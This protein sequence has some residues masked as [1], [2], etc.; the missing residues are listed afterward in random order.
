M[1]I[2]RQ[3]EAGDEFIELDR[4][5]PT[6]QLTQLKEDAKHG[7]DVV[8]S[9]FG[10]EER[11]NNGPIQ[12]EATGSEEIANDAINFVRRGGTLMIY[13]V[14]SRIDLVHWSPAKIFQ[15]EIKASIFASTGPF[16]RES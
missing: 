10:R 7:F 6:S 9:D 4:D 13:G 16:W 1:R 15:D 12:I 8:V 2:A 5:N 14:Y 3:L 11:V